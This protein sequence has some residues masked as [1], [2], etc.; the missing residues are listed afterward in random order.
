[1]AGPPPTPPPAL[2]PEP[3]IS[4]YPA[5]P[6]HSPARHHLKVIISPQHH[7]RY[8]HIL[9]HVHTAV[10]EFLQAP[11]QLLI[12]TLLFL[13]VMHL[14][15][16]LTRLLR[17]LIR[18]PHLNSSKLNRWLRFSSGFPKTNITLSEFDGIVLDYSRQRATPETLEIGRGGGRIG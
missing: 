11:H 4:P 3:T 14:M 7:P 2:S 17:V 6:V 5:S 16:P 10:L 9:V 1:M 12:L 13:L 18:V 8:L 15:V